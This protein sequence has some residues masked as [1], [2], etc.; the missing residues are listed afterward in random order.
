[1]IDVDSLLLWKSKLDGKYDKLCF[2]I[3]I[4]RTGKRKF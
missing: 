4:G 3:P 2:Y 1:M